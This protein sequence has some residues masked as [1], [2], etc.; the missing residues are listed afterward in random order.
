MC[1]KLESGKCP[2][3]SDPRTA[4]HERTLKGTKAR[5]LR[6]LRKKSQAES[7]CKRVPTLAEGG[8][9]QEDGGDNLA[10]ICLRQP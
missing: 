8:V 2:N 1:A 3:N 10:K 7:I 5:K 6:R 4:H 9:E